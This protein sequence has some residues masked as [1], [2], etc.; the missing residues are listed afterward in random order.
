MN[1]YNLCVVMSSLSFLG[2]S[3]SYFI[4]PKMKNEFIRFKMERLGLLTIILQLLGAIGLLVG[5]VC[6]PILLVSSGGLGVLM[7]AGLWVRI[8]SKDSMLVSL[9]AALL[10]ILNFYIFIMTLRT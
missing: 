8:K 7:L 9:P 4:L 5:L 1:L 6:K 3:I 2:Y 10:M